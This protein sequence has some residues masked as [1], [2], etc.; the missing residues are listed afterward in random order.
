MPAEPYPEEPVLTNISMSAEDYYYPRPAFGTFSTVAGL[1]EA[2]LFFKNYGTYASGKLGEMY[3][4]YAN[5]ADDLVGANNDIAQ[6]DITIGDLITQ[7]GGLATQIGSLTILIN[8]LSTD[9]TETKRQ[10]DEAIAQRGELQA[11]HG[12]LQAQHEELQAQ[13]GESTEARDELQ[14]KYDTTLSELR[15]AT[16]RLEEVESAFDKAG[17]VFAADNP[18][19]A[20]K[21]LDLSTFVDLTDAL[22]SED[23]EKIGSAIGTLEGMGINPADIKGET[24]EFGDK[25]YIPTDP[26]EIPGLFDPEYPEFEKDAEEFLKDEERKLEFFN[27]FDRA[28]ALEKDPYATPEDKSGVWSSL[29]KKAGPFGSLISGVAS[30]ASPLI[31]FLQPGEDETPG[32]EPVTDYRLPK[33]TRK[34]PDLNL[35]LDIPISGYK[36][37]VNLSGGGLIKKPVPPPARTEFPT[38]VQPGEKIPEFELKYED[39]PYVGLLPKEDKE[40]NYLQYPS[41]GK[42]KLKYPETAL[43]ETDLSEAALL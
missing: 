38:G 22:A 41:F 42:D 29:L 40:G 27:E 2:A 18:E 25:E 14:G 11:Q 43:L 9:N 26:P 17:N 31:K 12:E 15:D 21:G 3:I 33:I 13:L 32:G 4:L 20:D 28:K 16:E 10:R 7:I 23:P 1:Y 35:G 6:R 30:V 24:F 34:I 5:A 39:E 37:L 8:S 19:W 36:S